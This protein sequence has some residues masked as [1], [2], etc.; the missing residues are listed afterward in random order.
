MPQLTWHTLLMPRGGLPY[1]EQRRRR[2]GWGGGR[3]EAGEGKGTR[4]R[5]EWKLVCIE[6]KCKNLINKKVFLLTPYNLIPV[7]NT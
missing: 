6:N 1:S 3:C 2:S 4:E 7:L 5:R